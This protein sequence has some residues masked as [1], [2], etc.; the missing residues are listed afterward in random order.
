[1]QKKYLLLLIALFPLR[2]IAQEAE[3]D[4]ATPKEWSFSAWAEMFIIPHEDDIFNPTF[5][6]RHK[7]LH[8]EAR[9]NYE[10]KNTASLWAGYRFKFGKQ[11]K[12]VLVPMAA[13]V[14]GNT[15]GVAPGLEMEIMYK[16]FDFYSE[17]EHVFDFSSRENNFFY[18]YSELAIR[19]IHALRTGIMTQRTKLFESDRELQ[20][21]IFGEYYFGRFRAGVFYFSPFATDQFWIASFSVDF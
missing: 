9:Y 11:V 16:K 19:P 14:F 8:L 2:L 20:R 12:F 15:N 10:D 4:S 1:M 7:T 13:I 17:S 21:G 5:Y 18:M 3:S 6:A